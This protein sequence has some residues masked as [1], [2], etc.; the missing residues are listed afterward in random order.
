MRHRPIVDPLARLA[1]RCATSALDWLCP[2]ACVLCTALGAMLCKACRVDATARVAHACPRCAIA[3][4]AQARMPVCG[5]CQRRRP[6]FDRTLAAAWYAPPFDR[7]IQGLKYGAT[8]AYAPLL[9]D[10]LHG[11]VITADI[12]H[13]FDVVL[14]VPLS[15]GRMA[16]RGFNQ[17]IEIGRILADRLDRPLDTRSVL[18]IVDTSPQAA[19]PFD[20][21]RRNIRGAFSVIDGCRHTLVGSHVAIVDDVM[22]TGATLDELARTLKRA[23]VAA[24]TCLVVA[25]T[26]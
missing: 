21:R 10:L 12:P 9:A 8:L 1:T 14:P 3:L 25:R 20:A 16:E 7:L 11:R 5:R 13:F 6:A 19:L 26:P 15:R 2:P 18:R 4:P 24:V 22:T 23:G 17:S